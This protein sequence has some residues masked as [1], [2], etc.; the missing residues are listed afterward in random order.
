[1]LGSGEVRGGLHAV[2][3]IGAPGSEHNC[4]YCYRDEGLTFA[5]PDFFFATRFRQE[6]VQ[7]FSRRAYMDILIDK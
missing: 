1:L 5:E 7:A 3:E 4:R 2:S 6:F